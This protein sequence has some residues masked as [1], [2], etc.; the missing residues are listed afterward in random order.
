[1][2]LFIYSGGKVI[3]RI[4]SLEMFRI[5]QRLMHEV[6]CRIGSLEIL[7]NGTMPIYQV[8]CRIGSLEKTPL[9]LPMRE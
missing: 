9:L 6:I 8:I 7:P 1:M 2:G 5:N 3:C 4:G